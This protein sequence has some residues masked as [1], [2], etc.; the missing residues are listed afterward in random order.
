M[1][2]QYICC[3][4]GKEILASRGAGG[5]RIQGLCQNL[6]S[7][8]TH[9]LPAIVSVK[10]NKFRIR[11]KSSAW[12]AFNCSLFRKEFSALTVDALLCMPAL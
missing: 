1:Y 9:R 6:G 12:R 2:L 3:I 8:P 10:V 4:H 5:A 7:R 11:N